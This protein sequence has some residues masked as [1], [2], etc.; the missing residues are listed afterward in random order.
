MVGNAGLVGSSWDGIRTSAHEGCGMVVS[1]LTKTSIAGV[2][3]TVILGL[4]LELGS[5]IQF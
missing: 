3:L 1:G 4:G 2:V 5:L